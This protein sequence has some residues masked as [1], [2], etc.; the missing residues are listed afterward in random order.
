MIQKKNRGVT[1]VEVLI[2]LAVFLILMTPLVSS[3]ITSIKNTDSAK[4][5]QNRNDYAQVLMENVKNAPIDDLKSSTKVADFFPGSENVTLNLTP[6]PLFPEC[7]DFTI[8]GTTYLGTKHEKYSYQINGVY[9]KRTDPHGIMEDL[10]PTKAAFVPVTFSNYD[11]VATEAIITQKLDEK[12]DTDSSIFLDRDEV[13]GLRNTN[14]HRIV[15]IKMSGSK[16]SGFDV[17]CTLEY[18]DSGKSIEYEPYNQ[19]FDNI[20]NIYL[21]YNAGVYNNQTTNDRIVYDLSSV[22]FTSFG[23]KERINAFIIRT[24]EDYSDIIDNYKNDDGSYRESELSEL[25]DLLSTK[26]QQDIENS[27]TSGIKLYK[28]SGSGS[29]DNSIVTV[30]SASGVS[31]DNF[32]IYHNLTYTDAAGVKQSLVNASSNIASIVDTLDNATEEVWSIY[33]VK[34]WMQQGDNVD[35]SDKMVTLQGTRGGGE[36]E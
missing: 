30:S 36:I 32:R 29:R 20:P 24:S 5:T 4:V 35:T 12:T 10:D 14:A 26:L 3:M 2:A 19:H 33:N 16:G 15:T 22:D 11:D 34:I 21:M 31:A 25:T 8:T 28:E 27:R 9:E 1:L 6:S 18:T 23:E 17:V 7:D 13:S